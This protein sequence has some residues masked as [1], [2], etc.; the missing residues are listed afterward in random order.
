[1]LG[2]SLKRRQRERGLTL[3]QIAFDNLIGGSPEQSGLVEGVGFKLLLAL[4]E[5]CIV[6]ESTISVR[7]FSSHP[8]TRGQ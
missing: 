7:P 6:L 4:G 2:A 1:M 8:P 5:F 3:E